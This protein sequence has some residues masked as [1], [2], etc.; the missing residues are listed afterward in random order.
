MLLQTKLVFLFAV[1]V[2][3]SATISFGQDQ[4]RSD[5]LEPLIS[6]EEAFVFGIVEGVTEFNRSPNF[7]QR[8][9]GRS[10]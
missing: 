6:Y 7:N 5:P 1:T 9:P 2:L 8:I 4:E 10:F 3:A